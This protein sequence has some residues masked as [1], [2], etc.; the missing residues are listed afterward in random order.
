MVL[1]WL[2]PNLLHLSVAFAVILLVMR[3]QIQSQPLEWCGSHLFPLYIYQ[4]IPM[5]MFPESFIASY[6]LLYILSC[7]VIT[8]TIAKFY[9]FWQ[10]KL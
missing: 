5:L 6:H 9:R 1:P 7:L 2:W 10:I 8:I 3:L 4:R